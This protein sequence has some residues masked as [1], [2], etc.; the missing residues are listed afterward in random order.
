MFPLELCTVE[1]GQ[2]DEFA[3]TAVNGPV[4]VVEVKMAVPSQAL[5]HF[6]CSILLNTKFCAFAEMKNKKLNPNTSVFML[7]Y[8]CNYL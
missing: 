5:K 2:E 8:G 6:G 3:I 1:F 4:A 7:I